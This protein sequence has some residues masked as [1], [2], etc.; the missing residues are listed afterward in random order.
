MVAVIAVTMAANVYLYISI[1]KGF[2]PQQD[3]GIN[4]VLIK[5]GQDISYAAMVE[6]S[7]AMAKVVMADPDVQNVIYWVGAN[8]TVN[9]GRLWIDLK[10]FNERK[11]TATEIPATL[12]RELQYSLLH[13]RLEALLSKRNRSDILACIESPRKVTLDGL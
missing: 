10:P 7:H 9:T 8:P 12:H 13:P 4:N 1:P 6:R 11:A 5:A 3:A 2:F